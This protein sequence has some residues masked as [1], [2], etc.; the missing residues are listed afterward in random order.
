MRNKSREEERESKLPLSCSQNV[1]C[2][3]VFQKVHHRHK[4][5][6][7]ESHFSVHDVWPAALPCQMA[8]YSEHSPTARYETAFLQMALRRI[9][10]H[11]VRSARCVKNGLYVSLRLLNLK[12]WRLKPRHTEPLHTT[13]G[14]DSFQSAV[15]FSPH[16]LYIIHTIKHIKLNARHRAVLRS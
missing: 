12:V 6:K 13:A 9:Y 14:S 10:T 2:N 11:F 8:Y 4:P 15:H 7:P 16:F 3:I 5:Y 1:L